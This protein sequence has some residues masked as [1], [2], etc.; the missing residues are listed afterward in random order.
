MKSEDSARI[1]QRR[2]TT[3]NSFL[4]EAGL[5]YD[6]GAGVRQMPKS[7]DLSPLTEIFICVSPTPKLCYVVNT[8]FSFEF[9]NGITL[10]MAATIE[11]NDLSKTYRGGWIRRK[12]IEAHRGVSFSV[13][14]GEKF[15]LLDPNGVGKTTFIKVLRMKLDPWSPVW[16]GLGFILV[17]L[18]CSCIYIEPQEF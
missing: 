3:S 2:P 4:P 1:I 15:G 7:V 13:E 17:M 16:S 9:T 11:V 18:I 6:V 8:G 14:S 10:S 5:L 12:N